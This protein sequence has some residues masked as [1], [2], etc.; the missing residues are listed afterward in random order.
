[1]RIKVLNIAQPNAHNVIYS[2]KNVE[3]RSQATKIRG[4][5]AIYASKT[6]QKWRFEGSLVNQEECDFGSII[7]FVEVV[8]CITDKDVGPKTKKWFIGEYGWILANPIALKIPIKITPPR[9]AIIWWDLKDLELD[10]FLAELPEWLQK[11]L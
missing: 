7:G 1:M 5:I 2:G 3:N 8:D 6:V 9:G 10:K 4:L 11:R